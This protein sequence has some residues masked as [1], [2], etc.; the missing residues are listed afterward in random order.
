MKPWLL[1]IQNVI[2]AVWAVPW[3]STELKS[4]SGLGGLGWHFCAISP[5][6][7]PWAYSKLRDPQTPF[8]TYPVLGGL[9][10]SPTGVMSRTVKLSQWF[11]TISFAHKG[12]LGS[13]VCQDSKSPILK[14]ITKSR[15]SPPKKD[16]SG[17]F[18]LLQSSS[19]NVTFKWYL[20]LKLILSWPWGRTSENVCTIN[21]GNYAS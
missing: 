7:F 13:I 3:A 15:V 18:L 21:A 20:T 8:S 17:F 14:V 19:Q 4:L 12:F 11:K 10:P 6:W 2:I 1:E 16:G 5:P 9:E